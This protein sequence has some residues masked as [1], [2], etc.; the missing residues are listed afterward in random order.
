MIVSTP[1]ILEVS[2]VRRDNVLP[3]LGRSHHLSVHAGVMAGQSR[4]YFV[5]RRR[6]EGNIVIVSFIN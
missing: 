6:M 5:L 4:L 3:M 1:S 2:S